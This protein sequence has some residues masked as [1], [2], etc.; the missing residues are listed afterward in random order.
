MLKQRDLGQLVVE[1]VELVFS[2]CEFDDVFSLGMHLYI[3]LIKSLDAL[4]GL[5]QLLNG[6]FNCGLAC[7]YSQKL[8][9]VFVS[10]EPL[11]DYGDSVAH[12][13]PQ[14]EP[15]IL[16]IRGLC[17][18]GFHCMHVGYWL[19]IAAQNAVQWLFRVIGAVT[20]DA[21]EHDLLSPFA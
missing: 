16:Y 1:L 15:E 19:K 14:I 3:R 13:L 9:K 6:N 2:V 5:N 11:F 8:H 10:G 20:H 17:A 12:I 7:R 18:D 4:L 21:D